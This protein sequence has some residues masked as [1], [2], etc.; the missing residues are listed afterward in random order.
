[1][2]Q[3]YAAHLAIAQVTFPI[4]LYVAVTGVVIYLMLYH[5]PTPASLGRVMF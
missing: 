5:I 4:W 3:R 2:R 1:V